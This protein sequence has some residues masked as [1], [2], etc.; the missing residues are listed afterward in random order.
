MVAP[1]ISRSQ[2]RMERRQAM[3]LLALVL[4]VS[5]VSFALGVMVGRG[6]GPS[7]TA[8]V[9][10]LPVTA[11]GGGTAST[12]NPDLTFYD[13]LPKGG[14]LPLGSGINLPAS[15]TAPKNPPPA[16]APSPP[17]LMPSQAGSPQAAPSPAT[18]AASVP[19]APPKQ[20]AKAAPVQTMQP[21]PASSVKA[22]GTW[23]VQV[24]S[25]PAAEDAQKLKRR[26]LGKGFVVFV[27]EAKLAGKGTWYRV[28]VGPFESEGVASGAAGR[29]RD[30]EKLSV[31]VRKS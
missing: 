14:K 15:E 5:L 6:K 29:L 18:Q 26:L 10:R 31:M 30:E 1:V 13:S 8:A 12:A 2:R 3:L 20:A 16:P 28:I 22:A 23:I 17:Q 11:P 27:Q 25:F 7:P 24:G 9:E 19:T 21:T 4:A